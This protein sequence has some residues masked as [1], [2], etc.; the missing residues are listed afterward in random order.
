LLINCDAKVAAATRKSA[1]A[2]IWNELALR[3]TLLFAIHRSEKPPDEKASLFGPEAFHCFRNAWF[4]VF[5]SKRR[6]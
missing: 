2:L 4:P 6:P 5:F 1:D 3:V